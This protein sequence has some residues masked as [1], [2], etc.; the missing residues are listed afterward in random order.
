LVDRRQ[1]VPQ[2]LVEEVD[3]SRIAFHDRAPAMGRRGRRRR[4]MCGLAFNYNN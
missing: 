4:T 2:S 1:F 3:D